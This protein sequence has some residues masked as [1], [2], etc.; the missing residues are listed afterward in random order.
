[1][2]MEH[3]ESTTALQAKEEGM[4]GESEQNPATT[5]TTNL[6]QEGLTKKANS[7]RKTWS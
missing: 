7:I 6:N 3:E 5:P 1:M 2:K 4:R